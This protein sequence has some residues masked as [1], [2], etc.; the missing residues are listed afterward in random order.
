MNKIIIIAGVLVFGV[1][2]LTWIMLEIRKDPDQFNK[3]IKVGSKKW[4]R[5]QR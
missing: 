5:K 1:G 3:P 2:M 4:L